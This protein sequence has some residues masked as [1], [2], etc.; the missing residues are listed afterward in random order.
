MMKILNPEKDILVRT[1][2]YAVADQRSGIETMSTYA[3]GTCIGVAIISH[4]PSGTEMAIA[5]MHSDNIAYADMM[6]NLILSDLGVEKRDTNTVVHI[7]HSRLAPSDEIGVL[8]SAIQDRLGLE[9]KI[10]HTLD[11]P[12]GFVLDAATL[13]ISTGFPFDPKK[14]PTSTPNHG[15]LLNKV[16]DR[17][18][19]KKDGSKLF[20]ELPNPPLGSSGD[21]RP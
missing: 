18:N 6:L 9:L 12:Y 10:V 1:G 7:V 13:E 19:A 20:E 16:A 21:P 4:R 2:E 17:R 11:E 14:L 15:P 8:T 3:L 5:H